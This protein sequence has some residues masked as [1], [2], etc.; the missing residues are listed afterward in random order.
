MPET[1]HAAFIAKSVQ[2]DMQ[3]PQPVHL[4]T[5]RRQNRWQ[6][7]LI[8]TGGSSPPDL[9]MMA[10]VIHELGV[11]HMISAN[12]VATLPRSFAKSSIVDIVTTT[13]GPANSAIF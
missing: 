8:S 6:T 11:R 1:G 13:S 7:T 9:A 12:P 10:R 2:T 5:F 4:D 3:T